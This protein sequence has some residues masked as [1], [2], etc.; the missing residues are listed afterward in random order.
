ML[1]YED[2]IFKT[3]GEKHKNNKS[4]KLVS[5]DVDAVRSAEEFAKYA[6]TESRFEQ[7][8]QCAEHG[9]DIKGT[10]IFVRWLVDDVLREENHTITSNNLKDHLVRK[11]LSR[12]GSNLYKN[13][14]GYTN[15]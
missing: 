8:W 1:N 7:A 6:L 5:A 9:S 13:K 10:G 2:Y 4:P 3:K 14:L 15:V 11:A 12:E